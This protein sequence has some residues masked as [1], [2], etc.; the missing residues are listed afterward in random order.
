MVRASSSACSGRGRNA[1]LPCFTSSTRPVRPS[2]SFLDMMLAA[3]S[4]IAS[5][6][7]VTSRSAYSLRS[8]GA[9]SGGLT[10][11]GAA[12]LDHL[13]LGLRERQAGTEPRDRFELIERAAR[14]PEAA[15][16]HH[17]H[18]HAANGDEGGQHEGDLV[19]DAAGGVLVD[20][21][22]VSIR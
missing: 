9:I 8:A 15:A 22:R 1:P 3:M 10:D 18:G 17:G 16:G 11:Q 21:R 13:R 7:P 6:V 14:V 5:T 4:G 20:A 19:T 2:A 12:P